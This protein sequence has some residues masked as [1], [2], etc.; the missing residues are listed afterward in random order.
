M[1]SLCSVTARTFSYT[2]HIQ[3]NN[4]LDC[5]WLSPTLCNTKIQQ[6]RL[7]HHLLAGPY[8]AISLRRSHSFNATAHRKP[9]APS[10]E[11]NQT[12]RY[13]NVGAWSITI[14]QHHSTSNSNDPLRYNSKTRNQPSGSQARYLQRLGQSFLQYHRVRHI[15]L[16][17]IVNRMYPTRKLNHCNLLQPQREVRPDPSHHMPRLTE[18]ISKMW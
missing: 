2:T 6:T 17:S 3:G 1:I 5:R 16:L 4:I 14:V 10:D 15:F 7:N 18:G 12:S 8:C 9:H 13:D 11:P